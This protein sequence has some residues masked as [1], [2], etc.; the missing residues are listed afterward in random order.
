M[1]QYVI[2]FFSRER[3]NWLRIVE[4]IPDP[5]S[6]DPEDCDFFCLISRSPLPFAFD[7]GNVIPVWRYS[8][9]SGRY[10]P[11]GTLFFDGETRKIE[12]RNKQ[13]FLAMESDSLLQR[14][15]PSPNTES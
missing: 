6:V 3:G 5:Y 9:D 13:I 7:N 15:L 1:T 2:S 14:A 11:D 10:F 4:S 8:Y 12:S